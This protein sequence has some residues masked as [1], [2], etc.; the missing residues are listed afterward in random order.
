MSESKRSE[1]LSKKE[2]DQVEDSK[3]RLLYLFD[4]YY[5]SEAYENNEQNL[6]GLL[7]MLDGLEY[8]HKNHSVFEENINIK[9]NFEVKIDNDGFYYIED[10]KYCIYTKFN[11]RKKEFGHFVEKMNGFIDYGGASH[12]AVAYFN[13]LG[14]IFN[15]FRSKW[16]E[17]YVGK[18]S[19]R[20]LV[21]SILA[22]IPIRHKFAAHRQQDYHSE[23]RKDDTENLSVNLIGLLPSS[24]WDNDLNKIKICYLFPTKQRIELR[25]QL[26][27]E[28]I[29]FL[30]E[31]NEDNYLQFVPTDC[32]NTVISEIFTILNVFFS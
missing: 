32:H 23:P 18:E 26:A 9:E 31:N 17:K 7:D 19:R 14:K 27:V 20:N 28:G 2:I 6:L 21:P 16:F 24:R 13:I 22:L 12:E 11:K 29:E 25:N 4:Y 30:G 15:L 3:E 1:K 5:N 10:G 8:H